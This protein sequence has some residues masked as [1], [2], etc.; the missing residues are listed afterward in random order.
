M[1]VP[2]SAEWVERVARESRC[3]VCPTPGS[4]V[5]RSALPQS[6]PTP[7]AKRAVVRAV[8]QQDRAPDHRRGRRRGRRQGRA[9]G[10]APVEQDFTPLP[11]AAVGREQPRAEEQPQPGQPRQPRRQ[12]PRAAGHLVAR[13]PEAR[14]A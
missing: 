14:A 9:R 4:N 10:A 13:G 3:G 5:A 12:L 8:G 11:P 7:Q 6:P 2:D 1:A